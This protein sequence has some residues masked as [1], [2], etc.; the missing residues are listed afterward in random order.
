MEM[1]Q[2]MEKA[3]DPAIIKR[4]L[5][6]ETLPR[7]ETSNV[8]ASY[9]AE[10]TEQLT[11][12]FAGNPAKP[13]DEEFDLMVDAWTLTLQDAVPERRLGE[14]I[15]E[16]RRTRNSSFMLDVSE[17]C[18]AWQR[19][20]GAERSVPPVGTYDWRAKNICPHC[21]GTGTRPVIKRDSILGRDYTYGTSCPHEST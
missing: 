4:L 20:K 2:I 15:A 19:L 21:N 5:N 17:V 7:S 8:R 14:S 18:T 16:A 9:A 12:Y 3:T 11:M 6:A 13:I 10:V 1:E